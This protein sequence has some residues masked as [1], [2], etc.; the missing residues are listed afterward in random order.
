MAYSRLG[1]Y[2]L[3]MGFAAR[4][5]ISDANLKMADLP[6]LTGQLDNL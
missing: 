2:V 1:L 4:V 5:G 6:L 3:T